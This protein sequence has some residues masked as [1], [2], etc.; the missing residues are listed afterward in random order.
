MK[1]ILSHQLINNDYILTPTSLRL[2]LIEALEQGYSGLVIVAIEAM[3]GDGATPEVVASIFNEFGA[4]SLVCGLNPGG[5]D[6]PDPLVNDQQQTVCSNLGTPIRFAQVLAG[7]GVA[8]SVVVG[9]THAKHREPREW[10]DS[11]TA[12]FRGWMKKL[13]ALGRDNHIRF[14]AEGLNP[15]EDGTEDVF[16]RIA[17]AASTHDEIEGHF[18]IGHMHAHGLKPEHLQYYLKHAAFL[19]FANVGRWPLQ[20]DKGMDVAGFVQLIDQLGPQCVVG[21]EPFSKKVIDDFDLKSIVDTPYS[22]IQAARMNALYLK[23]LGRM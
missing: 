7:A 17:E 16:K 5:P 8:P 3:L 9:P 15:L 21:S 19:E 6:N 13:A 4:Q 20:V 11:M 18:D 10:N 23:R 1:G 12:R 2:W 22:G 14:A